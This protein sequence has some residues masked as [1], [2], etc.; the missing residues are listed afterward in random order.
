[1]QAKYSILISTN[2]VGSGKVNLFCKSF[3]WE[4][5]VAKEDTLV[6]MLAFFSLCVQGVQISNTL[7][8]AYNFL[9]RSPISVWESSL[10]S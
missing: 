7:D 1:M 9:T 5:S 6:K 3:P 10:E 8:F 2:F 4:R